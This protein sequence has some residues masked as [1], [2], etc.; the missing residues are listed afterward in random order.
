[1]A[2]IQHAPRGPGMQIVQNA[3]MKRPSSFGGGPN[4]DHSVCR[5]FAI[6]RGRSGANYTRKLHTGHL[7]RYW[8]RSEQPW[9]ATDNTR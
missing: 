6:P 4:F 5:R 9:K 3:G 2:M 7:S 8:D 1:M